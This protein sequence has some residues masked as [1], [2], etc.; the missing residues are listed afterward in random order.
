MIIKGPLPWAS[1]QSF[2]SRHRTVNLNQSAVTQC[3]IWVELLQV[4]GEFLPGYKYNTLT[5]SKNIDRLA[6]NGI[7]AFT[8]HSSAI[9]DE[10]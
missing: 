7:L 8:F 9:L 10:Q 5:Q 1:R 2:H 3:T 6:L 4:I